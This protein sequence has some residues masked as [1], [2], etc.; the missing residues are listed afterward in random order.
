MLGMDGYGRRRYGVHCVG[1][2]GLEFC[3]SNSF[4][5]SKGFGGLEVPFWP[6]V[7]DD[8]LAKRDPL[9]WCASLVTIA[10]KYT[11]SILDRLIVRPQHRDLRFIKAE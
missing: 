7:M 11:G 1:N 3:M 9:S 8:V 6:S 10:F 4:I 2:S 5:S